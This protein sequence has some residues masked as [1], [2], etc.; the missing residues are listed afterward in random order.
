MFISQG[1]KKIELMSFTGALSVQGIL[2]KAECPPKLHLDY[3]LRPSDLPSLYSISTQSNLVAL[4]Y[5]IP[6]TRSAFPTLNKL[7]QENSTFNIAVFSEAD[8][9]FEY[10]FIVAHSEDKNGLGQFITTAKYGLFVFHYREILGDSPQRYLQYIRGVKYSKST[11]LARSRR[12]MKTL[13]YTNIELENA[14]EMQEFF[15]GRTEKLEV[16]LECAKLALVQ[17][18]FQLEKKK[19]KC[20]EDQS[21]ILMC[22]L[23]NVRTK[24]V[25]LMPCGH[26]IFCSRCYDSSYK[27]KRETSVENELK[28]CPKCDAPIEDVQKINNTFY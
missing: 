22:S 15:C 21:I 3:I 7:L 4:L 12:K 10:I 5:D 14:K 18:Q 25:A 2:L 19:K 16:E 6:D 28:H 8:K 13:E 9:N 1:L 24:N 17:M 27:L 26:I 20:Q 23:C 11:F